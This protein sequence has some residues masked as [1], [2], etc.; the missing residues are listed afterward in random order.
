MS[1]QTPA[2]PTDTPASNAA[3]SLP[4]E[5]ALAVIEEQ[6]QTVFAPRSSQSPPVREDPVERSN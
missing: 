6:F 1:K 3:Q 5:Q 2:T 4:A